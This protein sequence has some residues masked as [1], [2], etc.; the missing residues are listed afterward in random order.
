M[1]SPNPLAIDLHDV[2]K[3]YKRRVHALRGISL[4]VH[5][6]E[7]FGLLG[8]NGAG[9]STLVKIMMTVVRPTRAD[10]FI[11]GQRIGHK[12]T[13]ARVGYL[14]ENHRFP[15]YLTGRQTIEFFASLANVDRATAR[16]RTNELLETIRM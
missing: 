11:L 12:P 16:R 8:P 9:K 1:V 10:G 6:G 2:A 4:Q 15:R 5:R 13:L 7:I 14:P 3:V